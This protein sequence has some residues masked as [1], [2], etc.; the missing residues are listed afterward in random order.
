MVTDLLQEIA[1]LADESNA[2]VISN[3]FAK[4]GI[5]CPHCNYPSN[6]D[7]F[8]HW[9]PRYK[10]AQITYSCCKR[11]YDNADYVINK[12]YYERAEMRMNNCKKIIDS[13]RPCMECKQKYNPT[14]KSRGIYRTILKKFPRLLTVEEFCDV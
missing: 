8:A 7:L 13:C 10:S 9:L 6:A 3:A 1:L 5:T 14:A 4:S 11:K 12:M 2:E